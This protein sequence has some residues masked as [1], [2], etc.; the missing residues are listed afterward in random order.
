MRK[1]FDE[2]EGLSKAERTGARESLVFP[3]VEA[4]NIR[5]LP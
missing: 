5:H 3:L 2:C 1:E 4:F